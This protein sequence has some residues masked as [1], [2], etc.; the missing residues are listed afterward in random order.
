M[1]AKTGNNVRS[2]WLGLTNALN[3]TNKELAKMADKNSAIEKMIK[4]SI[5]K[6]PINRQ[7][8]AAFLR[9][10]KLFGK[11]DGKDRTK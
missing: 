11:K 2:A 10:K 3:I 6:A 7:L 8:R 1:V 5:A 9:I 4:T